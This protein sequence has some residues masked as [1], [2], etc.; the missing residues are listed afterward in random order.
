LTKGKEPLGTFSGPKKVDG[1]LQSLFQ[2]K[3]F[4]PNFLWLHVHAQVMKGHKL[5][6]YSL[7]KESEYFIIG[8]SMYAFDCNYPEH[9]WPIYEWWTLISVR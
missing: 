1:Y 9:L 6:L 7:M 8:T 3:R 4:I 5:Y 2:Q